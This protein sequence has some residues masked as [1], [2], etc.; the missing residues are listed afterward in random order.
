MLIIRIKNVKN[1][2][3]EKEERGEKAV[4]V[5]ARSPC[6][7]Q[8]KQPSAAQGEVSTEDSPAGSWSQRQS[9]A[10]PSGVQL[11]L[12]DARRRRGPGKDLP[13]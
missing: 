10:R 2:R 9:G 6:G 7:D 12:S 3:A 13:L 11:L 4:A 1:L 5:R 8:V